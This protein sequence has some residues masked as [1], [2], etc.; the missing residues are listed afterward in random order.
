MGCG[1]S[2][3]SSR[4]GVWIY[5]EQA[6]GRGPKPRFHAKLDFERRRAPQENQSEA[7]LER[8]CRLVGRQASRLYLANRPGVSTIWEL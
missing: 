2:G 7:S 3:W 6:K 5:D 4:R 1:R 8:F